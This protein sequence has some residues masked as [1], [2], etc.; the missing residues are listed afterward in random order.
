MKKYILWYS[1]VLL[2]A[3]ALSVL[4]IAHKD[5]ENGWVH[6]HREYQGQEAE[7][8]S[9]E[10][11]LFC[12]HL[13]VMEI[14]TGGQ[15]IP[16]LQREKDFITTE[17]MVFD[18]ENGRNHLTD[19]PTLTCR[20]NI[21]YRGNS[22]LLFDKHSY[23]FNTVDE[24]GA[25]KEYSFMGMPEDN[26]WALNGPFLDK[27]LIRNYMCMNLYGEMT[28][29]APRVRFFEL[30]LDGE[31]Q[32]VYLM[33]EKVSRSEERVNITKCDPNDPFTSYIVRLD[34]GDAPENELN[35]FSEYA[36][37]IK[38]DTAVN[39]YAFDIVYPGLKNL[40]PELKTYIED[41]L[42]RI[43]KAIF[44]YDYDS[45]IYGYESHLDVSSFVDYFIFNEFM[46][47]Y[48]AGIYS[49]YLYKDVRGK[50]TIGPVW[51]FNNACDNYMNEQHNGDGFGIYGNYF[52]SMLFKEED[53]VEQVIDRYYELRE[54]VLNEEYIMQYIDETVC[55][56]GDAAERN[57]SVWGYSFDPAHVNEDNR[58]EPPERNPEDYEE[59][60]EQLKNFIK[61]RGE[62][63][64]HYICNLR[65]YSHESVNK[66]YNH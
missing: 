56:L 24:N 36:M 2:I 38:P 21:R 64:D 27:T 58:L 45:E 42:S 19:E 15:T 26:S 46:Q 20:A 1:A 6:Q 59:A 40:T 8:C 13:P 65:Q 44:S 43:E 34:R 28:G 54:G 32:G 12:S 16:G 11:G 52:Y 41:D 39:K 31:Y 48:D 7:A 63:L 9:H 3:G 30:W 4:V 35:N 49:T 53:F 47:N 61:A 62:W 50:L 60:I 5:T 18:K 29:Y 66:L 51:D 55:F 17:V 57:F 25:D 22:S 33:M 14:I 10:E 23:N 37:K